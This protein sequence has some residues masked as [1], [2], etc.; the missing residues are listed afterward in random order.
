[1]GKA[2]AYRCIEMP[3]EVTAVVEQHGPHEQLGW[4]EVSVKGRPRD[5][6]KYPSIRDELTSE[7]RS[8]LGNEGAN[9]G[10]RWNG[11]VS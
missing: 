4:M 10:S 1:M 9:V 11:S 6:G 2:E 8:E 5:S 7:E 3:T